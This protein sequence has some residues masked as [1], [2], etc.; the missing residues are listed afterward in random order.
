MVSYF[1]ISVAVMGIVILG[2]AIG[3]ILS[4][5]EI[6]GS[7]GGLGN[8]MGDECDFCGKKDECVEN[9]KLEEDCRGL[10]S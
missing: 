10:S 2:M 7:C 3:V 8:V 5:K 6:K 4:N 9:K 1:F